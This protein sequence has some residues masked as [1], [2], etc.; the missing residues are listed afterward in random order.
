MSWACRHWP[1]L[2]LQIIAEGSRLI[3]FSHG[4]VDTK[5]PVIGLENM[6]EIIKIEFS[7]PFPSSFLYF[8]CDPS[9]TEG[10]SRTQNMGE[11]VLFYTHQK[12]TNLCNSYFA[13]GK[14]RV[15]ICIVE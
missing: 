5:G 13:A 4:A 10:A 3:P 1:L 15:T 8:S 2:E 9:D 7:F 14:V 12:Q 6:P 11:G